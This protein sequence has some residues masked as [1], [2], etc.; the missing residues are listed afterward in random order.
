M[1]SRNPVYP[2]P[3]GTFSKTPD[4]TKAR[5]DLPL[6][7]NR[8]GALEPSLYGTIIHAVLTLLAHINR[9]CKKTYIN[10]YIYIHIYIYIY[11]YI[12]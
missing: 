11:I 1:R 9:I 8:I 4:L 2:L 12:C 7:D 10:I 3:Q 5:Q 6:H